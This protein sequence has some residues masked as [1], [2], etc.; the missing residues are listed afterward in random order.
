MGQGHVS[1]DGEILERAVDMSD[2]KIYGSFTVSEVPVDDNDLATKGYVDSLFG[3]SKSLI[4]LTGTSIAP[5]SSGQIFYKAVSSST[6]FTLNV[7]NVNIS[8][9]D[10][11]EFY[12]MISKT[13]GS[14]TFP[15]AWV[16]NGGS[17]P[18]TSANA[19]YI[20]HIFTID[21]GTT[22]LGELRN[23]F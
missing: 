9:D 8:N 22:W 15:S 7:D 1:F 14:I 10:L 11:F 23:S 19:F 3:S 2:I 6:V 12:L 5:T 4:T 20:F 13:G 16:W 17:V 21:G 18:S